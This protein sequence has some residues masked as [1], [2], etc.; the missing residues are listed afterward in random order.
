MG[1]D[2]GCFN[3]LDFPEKNPSVRCRI[4]FAFAT[5]IPGRNRSAAQLFVFTYPA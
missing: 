3:T 1:C 5:Q 2:A 4:G